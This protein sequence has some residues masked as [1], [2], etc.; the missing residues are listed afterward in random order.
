MVQ[1]LASIYMG[2]R[3]SLPLEDIAQ[4]GAVSG[5]IAAVGD[6]VG[7]ALSAY[8]G[9][10]FA[11]WG[12]FSG[13]GLAFEA[14]YEPSL[15]TWVPISAVPAAGGSSQ[16]TLSSQSAANAY[17]V[18]A[19]GALAVRLRATALTA[20]PMNVRAIPVAMM[21]DVAPAVAGG[22]VDVNA[23]S[24][25]SNKLIGD[26]S[27]SP[28]ATSAGLATVA[29]L[30]SAAASTNAGSVKASAGRLYKAHGYNAATAVR[31]LK[32]YNK[33]SA[34]TVGTDVPVATIPLKPS[35]SFDL[36]LIPIGQYFSTGIAYALTTGAADA[37]TGALTAADVVGLAFWYA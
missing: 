35:D 12:T 11:W 14:S 17:E 20:G 18:Y 31:F 6:T 4:S 15:S 24:S 26:V 10:V 27:L 9:A 19:P 32:L 29:R 13:V 7:L 2:A 5:A 37:D 25:S 36:D 28:R 1:S 30:V 8:N 16:T 33:A 22:A 23:I 21:Q 34:P 3:G